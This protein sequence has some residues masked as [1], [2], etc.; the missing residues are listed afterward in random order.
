MQQDDNWGGQPTGKKSSKHKDDWGMQQDDGWGGSGATGGWGMGG[1]DGRGQQS[2]SHKKSKKDQTQDSAWGG[3]GGAWGAQDDENDDGWGGTNNA[4]QSWGGWMEDTGKRGAGGTWGDDGWG[5]ET[6]GEDSRVSLTATAMHNVPSKN[7]PLDIANV[8]FLDS[9]G[10]AFGSATNAFFGSDRQARDRFHWMFPPD[11][12]ERVSSMMTCIQ[13]VAYGLGAL[14]LHKFVQSGERG[15]LFTNAAFRLPDQPT[16]P[17]FDWVAF[18]MLQN[19]MDKTLQ[20][21][22]AFYDPGQIVLVFVYL[23]SHTGNSVAIWRRKIPVPGNVRLM[24]QKEL[25]VVKKGLRPEK[26]YVIL[27][28]ETP[29]P[30]TSPKS[31]WTSKAPTQ[32]R[33]PSIA[34]PK[35]KLLTKQLQA[36]LLSQQPAIGSQKANTSKANTSKAKLSKANTPQ[37][38]AKTAKVKKRRWW[39]IFTHI[40]SVRPE[41]TKVHHSA[42]QPQTPEKSQYPASIHFAFVAGI[43]LPLTIIPYFIARRQASHLQGRLKETESAMRAL[44][45][46]LKVTALELDKIK[47]EQAFRASQTD[48]MHVAVDELKAGFSQFQTDGARGQK[49]VQEYVV[50]L[51]RQGDASRSSHSKAFRDVGQSL[52]N[53]ATFVEEM[54]ANPFKFAN[55]GRR[56]R[57]SEAVA[58]LRSAASRLQQNPD[59]KQMSDG[60][61]VPPEGGG[62]LERTPPQPIQQSGNP[63]STTP[64]HG[65]STSK[66]E[67]GGG[68]PEEQALESHEVIELQTF[69]ERKAWIE[70]KIK[71]LEKLPPIEVFWGL[72]ALRESAEDIPGLPTRENLRQWTA[73]H[74]I[75][76][77]QTEIFDQ[78]ELTKLRKL[79]KAATQRNLSPEDTDLIELTLT[80]IYALDKL[81]HLLRDRSD[82][83]DLLG[84]RLDWEEN[85]SA[86]WKERRRLLEDLE[87]FISSRA[88]WSPSIYETAATKVED[89][90]ILTRRGSVTSLASV[91]SESS[92]SNPMFSRNARFKLAELLSRD[93]AQFGA[94]VTNLS[95]N[96]VTTAGRLLDKLIDHSRRPVPDVLLDEQDRLEDKGI[97]QMENVGKFVLSLVL[98]WRKADEIYVETMKDQI[99]AK[100][101]FEEIQTANMY[102]PT[103]RQSATFMSQVETLLKRLSIRGNPA[104]RISTFPKPEHHL[105]PQQR[106]ANESLAKL[107]GEEIAT[108]T[109]LVQK[110]ERAAKE[111]REA[112]EAIDRVE[113]IVANA[114]TLSESFSS[115]IQRLIEGVAG[116]NDDGSPPDLMSDACL[117]PSRHSVFLA[118]LPS[119]QSEASNLATKADQLAKESHLAFYPLSG[120]SVDPI[121]K[122]DAIEVM[123]QLVSVKDQSKQLLDSTCERVTRL[124]EARQIWTAMNANIKEL[125]YVQQDIAAQ[126]ERDCW[127][128]EA[129]GTGAP[130]TPDSPVVELA[131]VTPISSTV[132]ADLQSVGENLAQTVDT[133]LQTLSP[134]LEKPLN[135]R[136]SK[137]AKSVRMFFDGLLRMS[138]IL[139]T[140]QQQNRTMESV[141]D[142]YMAFLVRIEDVKARI[143]SLT[144]NVLGHD[145]S[146]SDVESEEESAS[147]ELR[148]I[149]DAVA[150]F[151]GGLPSRVPFVSKHTTVSPARST[152][153]R[154]S[155]SGKTDDELENPLTH[156]PLDL[157]KLDAA[158]RSDSNT[159]A[160]QLNGVLE[161]VA[162]ASRKLEIA[163][164]AKKVDSSVAD[165]AASI[166]QANGDLQG[167][168]DSFDSLNSIPQES[169]IQHID[170]L[171]S[172]VDQILNEARPRIT[173]SFSPIR[174]LLRQIEGSAHGLEPSVRQ[175]LY[176]SRVRSADEAESRFRSWAKEISGLKSALTS[177]RQAEI[178]RLEEQRRAEEERQREEEARRAAEEAERQ[179]KEE[180]ERLREEQRR[181]EEEEQAELRRK[182]E[183]ERRRREEE[184]ERE[185]REKEQRE[186]EER[187]RKEEEA[188]AKAAQEQEARARI[189]QTEAEKDRLLN[190]RREME[191]RLHRTEAELA[192]ERRLQ[193]EKER[194]AFERSQQEKIQLEAEARLRLLA[195][196]QVR[197]ELVQAEAARVKAAVEEK[198]RLEKELEFVKGEHRKVLSERERL[199]QQQKQQ[200]AE[201]KNSVPVVQD[202]VFGVAGPSKN[203]TSTTQPDRQLQALI[204]DLRKRLRSLCINELARP[205]KNQKTSKLPGKDFVSSLRQKFTILAK[206]ASELPESSE[207]VSINTELRSFRSELTRSEQLLNDI[208]N[209]VN[210]GESVSKCD[211]VLSD[212][213]EHIDS[214]PSLPLAVSNLHTSDD[215]APP[216]EQ[217]L[218]RV[219]FTKSV[220]DDMQVAFEAIS[221][222][223]R[224]MSE[225]SRVHQTWVE[226]EEMAN[227]RIGGGKSRPVSSTSSYLSSG[228]ESTTS[229]ISVLS[230]RGLTAKKRTSYS[231]LSVSSINVKG[232]K[233]AP[234]MPP[235]PTRR[236]VSGESRRSSSRMS[237]SS[238]RS[239]SGPGPGP[240]PAPAPAPP[241]FNPSRDFWSDASLDSWDARWDIGNSKVTIPSEPFN[242]RVRGLTILRCSSTSSHYYY[243]RIDVG[244]CTQELAFRDGT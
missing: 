235:K 85:R 29:K 204:L 77:K 113:T 3:T 148:S 117:E 91:A 239:V 62:S 173:R 206:D 22:V 155:S 46:E 87:T 213:L 167:L 112:W 231:N 63:E 25:S 180:E 176:T 94:R 51:E 190:E 142:D 13:T 150:E 43:L 215:E 75:I 82:N 219:T 177:K 162:K 34:N 30:R 41:A 244:P 192:E 122:A 198:T 164:L 165:V 130:P 72:D 170:D 14:G 39:H 99:S 5:D 20:E 106:E 225:R 123:K 234:P 90:P 64:D 229:S 200:Q 226:L 128:Q 102:H 217:L 17:V 12:D 61:T 95:H 97:N 236:A 16:Q 80:T 224:A 178:Q 4:D 240:G 52:S 147:L 110:V 8:K 18:D 21:S 79:T 133:P 158:V 185:R 232:G 68:D 152:F 92:I 131:P 160:M 98:Q 33:T 144:E 175:S 227:D 201:R 125:Q 194:L 108:A 127:K 7:I 154:R 121:F 193:K 141:R 149:Q 15:A 67:A 105:F 136:L 50:A 32:D 119:I 69:S 143:S 153:Q 210:L 238:T 216:E 109:E 2:K 101:L 36:Q 6:K 205:S 243:F 237:I 135:D 138:E 145:E 207:N 42:T 114:K 189:A 66:Q 182:E 146:I 59:R 84:I 58:Q 9:G 74:D 126:M 242:K 197:E 214:Y 174:D 134:T 24:L 37:A 137:K 186:E 230:R 157:T 111:Y 208:D 56:E 35:G 184:A 183:E 73:E 179:R 203:P 49:A 48:E 163:H 60:P 221:N 54:G 107:L 57:T 115:I 191:A 100:D 223:G 27:L 26:D 222:D 159:Y 124:R 38:Q 53:I 78:G 65:P 23:P 96:R 140:I 19:T 89:S 228:M 166:Q 28:D 83:L 161:S 171:D 151:V 118:L 139:K 86:S 218:S 103:S 195:E 47:A 104:A 169:I 211:T 40:M 1:D 44:R 31:K 188:K 81:L 233:L 202:D 70:E 156:L 76:E 93:A 45:R 241:P 168:V 11:K 120:E 172:K 55:L 212:L 10:A 187:R 209:L 199:E 116:E 220:I 88:R 71:F 181:K 196:Q 132:D 129:I